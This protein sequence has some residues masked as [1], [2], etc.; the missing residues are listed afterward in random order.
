MYEKYLHLY[1]DECAEAKAHQKRLIDG[2]FKRSYPHLVDDMIRVIQSDIRRGQ[3]ASAKDLETM[4]HNAGVVS[5]GTLS[6]V[7]S[8]IVD[9]VTLLREGKY[10]G[11]VSKLIETLGTDEF[12]KQYMDPHWTG[13]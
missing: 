2:M 6:L 4:F 10:H 11:Y 9:A 13:D 7:P 5:G 8:A 3:D 12:E 1:D